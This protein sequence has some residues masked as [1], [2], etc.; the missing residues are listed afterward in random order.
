VEHVLRS[1]LDTNVLTSALISSSRPESTITRIV[2]AGIERAYVLLLPAHV[3]AEM[4]D[5]VATTPYL[6]TRT[7]LPAV[8]RFATSLRLAAEEL[9]PLAVPPDRV[10][11]DPDD[12]HLLAYA[13][14][15]QADYLVTGDKDLLVLA[16]GPFPFRIVSPAAFLAILEEAGLA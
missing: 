1:L 14:A 9:P 13:A 4:L 8:E 6:A 3:L 10:S 12:D 15:G 7:S 5:A 2:R 16:G 11:R